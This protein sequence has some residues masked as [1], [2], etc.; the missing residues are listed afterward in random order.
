M[1]AKVFTRA[2]EAGLHG[3]DGGLKGLGDLRMAAAFL[4]EGEEGAILRAE[5][6]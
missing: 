1:F 2:V 6:G 4:H 5:L 3:G